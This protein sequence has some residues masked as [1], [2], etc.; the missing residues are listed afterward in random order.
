[1][2][3]N[4]IKKIRKRLKLTQRAAAAL[5]R[6]SPNTWARWERGESKPRGLHQRRLI[7]NLP[8][9]VQKR[10]TRRVHPVM[11]APASPDSKEMPRSTGADWLKFAGTW[12][13]DDAERCLKLVHATRGLAKF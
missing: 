13:G 7:R 2:S 10:T 5:V 1:M 9:V 8:D 12:V 6:V 11:P 4:A 3:S